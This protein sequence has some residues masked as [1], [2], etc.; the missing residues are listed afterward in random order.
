MLTYTGILKEG[1]F[2]Q[3]LWLECSTN[4]RDFL[5]QVKYMTFSSVKSLTGRDCAEQILAS[6]EGKPRLDHSSS[7]SLFL[8]SHCSL[9]YVVVF[10]KSFVNST[11][12]QWHRIN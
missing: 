3:N 4:I 8:T 7:L 2:N 10:L 5:W 1:Q 12:E 11:Q 9:G 6:P